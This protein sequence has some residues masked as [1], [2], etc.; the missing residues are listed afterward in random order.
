MGGTSGSLLGQGAGKK[1]LFGVFVAGA[2]WRQFVSL[3]AA[4]QNSLRVAQFSLVWYG[5]GLRMMCYCVP[6]YDYSVM[7]TTFWTFERFPL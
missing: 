1:E 6:T 4:V 5:S 2:A 3:C 7:E